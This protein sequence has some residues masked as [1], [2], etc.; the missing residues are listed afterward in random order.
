VRLYLVFCLLPTLPKVEEQASQV[1][2]LREALSVISQ[3]SQSQRLKVFL[4]T[5]RDRESHTPVL[6][7]WCLLDRLA[8]DI[9]VPTRHDMPRGLH[10]L[11]NTCYLNSLL[12]VCGIHGQ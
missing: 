1:D 12:Q 7:M 2:K 4:D 8:G 3:V 6:V 11:G 10:Q 9:V 5:G